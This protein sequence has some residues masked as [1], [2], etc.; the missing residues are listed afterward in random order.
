MAPGGRPCLVVDPLHVASLARDGRRPHG[1]CR[2]VRGGA[3]RGGLGLGRPGRLLGVALCEIRCEA[4]L[5]GGS[6]AVHQRGQMFSPTRVSP[7]PCNSSKTG[8]RPMAD[9][10]SI[11]R[12]MRHWLFRSA[13]RRLS[14]AGGTRSERCG[15]SVGTSD[16]HS[17]PGPVTEG[18][19]CDGGPRLPL[20]VSASSGCWE[21]P[22][23]V[24]C[25]SVVQRCEGRRR[26]AAGKECWCRRAR[27]NRRRT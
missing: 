12:T 3:P 1:T 20:P 10:S 8:G 22:E 17:S 6:R 23:P 15:C 27:R 24:R 14:R 26:S 19:P 4:V 21:P 2:G 13:N 9:G 11:A 5:P 7:M 25:G 16:N 18:L